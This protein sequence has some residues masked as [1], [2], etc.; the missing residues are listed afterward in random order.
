MSGE[1]TRETL[2]GVER[3]VIGGVVV[4]RKEFDDGSVEG[5]RRTKESRPWLREKPKMKE[6][7][8]G[9]SQWKRPDF[10]KVGMTQ[11]E[12]ST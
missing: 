6:G 5:L 9:F 11:Q 1:S 10:R 4:V 3:R 12:M 8:F 7:R 2:G